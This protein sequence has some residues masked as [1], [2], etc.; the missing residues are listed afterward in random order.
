MESWMIGIRSASSNHTS[1]QIVL[2]L[3]VASSYTVCGYLLLVRMPW[4]DMCA[5][6][7]EMI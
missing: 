7:N 4:M 6:N 5:Q 2:G 3:G 1:V